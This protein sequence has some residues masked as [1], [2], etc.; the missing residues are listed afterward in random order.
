[1]L[2]LD[3]RRAILLPHY[4]GLGQEMGRSEYSAEDL[5][6][7]TR[8]GITDAPAVYQYAQYSK[9]IWGRIRLSAWYAA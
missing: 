4:L 8:G 1:M 9:E 3:Y 2:L 6:P 5:Y 7:E